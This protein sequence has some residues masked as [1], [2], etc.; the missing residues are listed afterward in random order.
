MITGTVL[1]ERAV[2]VRERAALD[3]PEATLEADT[4]V[5]LDEEAPSLRLPPGSGRPGR[6][7]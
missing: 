7:R 6:S 5:V 4:R 1:P 3:P 2:D